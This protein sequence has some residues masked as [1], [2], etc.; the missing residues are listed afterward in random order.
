MKKYT[1]HCD[2]LTRNKEPDILKEMGI[3]VKTRVLASDEMVPYL[4]KKLHEEV[5]EAI[6][7]PTEKEMVNEFIDII[8]AVHT[9]LEVMGIPEKEFHHLAQ[10]KKNLKGEYKQG[11]CLCTVTL[12]ED[13]PRY[14]H[15]KDHPEN[16]LVEEV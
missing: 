13:H 9:L 2:K 8:D 15:Y 14:M 6:E 5:I 10:E 7:A 1:F 3:E 4:K 12:S 11:V 16:Y